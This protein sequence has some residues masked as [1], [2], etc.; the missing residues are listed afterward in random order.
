MPFTP[1]ACPSS[2]PHTPVAALTSTSNDLPHPAQPS[3]TFSALGPKSSTG[4]VVVSSHFAPKSAPPAAASTS[5]TVVPA[6]R[7]SPSSCKGKERVEAPLAAEDEDEFD[8]VDDDIEN[9]DPAKA[10]ALPPS[11]QA[12]LLLQQQKQRDE[13]EWA[14]RKKPR[15]SD[16]SGY[17]TGASG[18]EAAMAD[19]VPESEHE[20]EGDMLVDAVARTSPNKVGGAVNRSSGQQAQVMDGVEVRSHPVLRFDLSPLTLSDTALVARRGRAPLV[21][22]APCRAHARVPRDCRERNGQVQGR[23]G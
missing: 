11:A 16:E 19:E 22:R 10:L 18:V 8:E 2:R 6:K 14:R 21:H 7:A 5:A 20:G 13:K 3:S 1:H 4:Q 23:A 17:A 12:A 9:V 15:V